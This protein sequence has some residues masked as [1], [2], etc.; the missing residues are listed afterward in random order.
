[1]TNSLATTKFT[2][3]WCMFC[4]Q[5]NTC[6][7]LRQRNSSS[8]AHENETNNYNCSNATHAKSKFKFKC[9]VWWLPRQKHFSRSIWLW[10][11]DSNRFWYPYDSYQLS[12]KRV[13]SI[14]QMIQCFLWPL[15]GWIEKR[16]TNSLW[17]QSASFVNC[18]QQVLIA[19]LKK[20]RT[21][22]QLEMHHHF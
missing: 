8:S 13:E 22:I 5:K 14:K 21:V 20:S 11:G 15:L 1:M 7:D 12:L 3:R 2:L 9:L 10:L 18:Q 16:K 6:D 17:K 4:S 19:A